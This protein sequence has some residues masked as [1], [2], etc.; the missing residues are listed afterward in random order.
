M[1]RHST[2]TASFILVL[3]A[4]LIFSLSL[5]GFAAAQTGNTNLGTAPLQYKI[6]AASTAIGYLTNA[7][8]IGCFATVNASNKIRLGNTCRHGD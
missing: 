5:A 7:T 2:N 1:F 3:I 4:G 6:T 8:A